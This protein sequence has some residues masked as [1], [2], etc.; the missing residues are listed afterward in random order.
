[1]TDDLTLPGED[2]TRDRTQPAS[3]DLVAVPDDPDDV[4]EVTL[5]PEAVSADR[6][7]TAWIT[8]DV[9]DLI[10]VEEMR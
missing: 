8:I 10:D 5:R 6:L 9:D 1:M 3:T 7:A 4:A 2:R